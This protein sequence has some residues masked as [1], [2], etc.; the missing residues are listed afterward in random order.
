VEQNDVT[1]ENEKFIHFFE[2]HQ[3]YGVLSNFRT[4]DLASCD[5]S[6]LTLSSNVRM[7][8]VILRRKL[9]H[10]FVWYL[11]PE[12]FLTIERMGYDWPTVVKEAG[13][14]NYERVGYIGPL[15]W[16]SLLIKTVRITSGL[17]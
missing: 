8:I 9:V 14:K 2:G 13:C 6:K 16:Q 10:K 7:R 15:L 4:T 5:T 12:H 17:S 1:V 3:A 11:K